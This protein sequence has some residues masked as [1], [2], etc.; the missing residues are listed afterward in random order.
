MAVQRIAGVY[1]ANLRL[2]SDRS[3]ILRPEDVPTLPNELASAVDPDDHYL[4]QAQLS[5]AGAILVTTDGDLCQA[6]NQAGL[7]CITRE[8]FLSTYF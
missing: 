1:V 4:V 8:E 7:A 3:L 6:V 2:N 5:T